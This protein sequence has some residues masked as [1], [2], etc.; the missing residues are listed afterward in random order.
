MSSMNK[1]ELRSK[2]KN[3]NVRSN[4][5]LAYSIYDFNESFTTLMS[6]NSGVLPCEAYSTVTDLA[7][8]LGLS[9]SVPRASAVW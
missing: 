5:P 2:A 1:I 6:K 8:F 9:T 4:L 7:R 3:I